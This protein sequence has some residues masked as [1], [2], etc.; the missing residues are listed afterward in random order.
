[1]IGDFGSDGADATNVARMV[2]NSGW[3]TDYILTLGDNNYGKIDLKDKD[4]EKKLVLA[5]VASSSDVSDPP[6]TTTQTS[7][8]PRNSSSPL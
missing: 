5:T 1:V 3:N 6:V 8:A 4:W 2:T 7:P